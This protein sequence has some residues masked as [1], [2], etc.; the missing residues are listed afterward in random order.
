ML[1]DFFDHRF[2]LRYLREGVT[3]PH[4]DAFAA[5][6]ADQGFTI[7]WAR[8]LLRGVAH[9]GHWLQEQPTALAALDEGVM[10]AFRAHL[11]RCRCVRR[12][13]GRLYYCRSG[14]NRFL[15]WARE[16]GLVRT[17]AS[18]ERVPLLIQN[19]EAWMREHRNVAPSTLCD[20]YRLHLL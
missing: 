6:L 11:S 9:L 17:P 20:A 10:E 13:K 16:Q 19:F 12:N 8:G 14:S 4:M 1:D 15:A 5:A 7:G 3:G 18:A 2:T